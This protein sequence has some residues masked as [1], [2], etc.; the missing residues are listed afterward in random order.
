MQAVEDP[1]GDLVGGYV[2]YL[3]APERDLRLDAEASQVL[4][5]PAAGDGDEALMT[6]KQVA[7]GL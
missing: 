2:R 6:G 1:R 4:V 7:T 5:L 3:A